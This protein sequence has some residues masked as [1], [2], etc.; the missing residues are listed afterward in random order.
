MISV[1]SFDTKESRLYKAV[2]NSDLPSQQ[3]LNL[4]I[5]NWKQYDNINNYCFT[6][7]K[8]SLG[9]Y[10]GLSKVLKHFADPLYLS[11][12]EFS[13]WRFSHFNYLN[14]FQSFFLKPSQT[15]CGDVKIKVW[16]L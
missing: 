5:Y 16:Q 4:K 3:Y 12:I 8:Y 9:E 15:T 6:V 11:R 1:G 7:I 2:D 10:K 13:Q 14:W